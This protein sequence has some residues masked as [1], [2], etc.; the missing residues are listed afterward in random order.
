M[1]NKELKEAYAEM[2]ANMWN[3]KGTTAWDRDY[4][5]ILSSTCIVIKLSDDTLIGIDKPHIETRFCYSYDEIGNLDSIAEAC[6]HASRGPGKEEFL[7][8]NLSRFNNMINALE[9][10]DE[11]LYVSPS[12]RNEKF[13]G[14]SFWN[15][16]QHGSVPETY[17]I[18][19]AQDRQLILQAYIKAKEM[20]V[21]RLNTYLKKYGL[22]K[23]RSWSYSSND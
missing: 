15:T 1:T 6:N 7:N 9:D 16:Y 23:I 20:F 21:K 8:D 10:E 2:Y 12:N 19:N 4:K 11:T 22:S 3:K 18:V 13:G 14:I 17:R 5:Y